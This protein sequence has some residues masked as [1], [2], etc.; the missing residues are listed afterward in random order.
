MICQHLASR[1]SGDLKERT[2]ILVK[3]EL[4]QTLSL[5]WQFAL[6]I[7]VLARARVILL[8]VVFVILFDVRVLL[9][10][11]LFHSFVPRQAGLVF[12]FLFEVGESII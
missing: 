7:T 9:R 8:V 12:E 5:D 2:H 1:V 4:N 6:G 10:L 11:W 3:D